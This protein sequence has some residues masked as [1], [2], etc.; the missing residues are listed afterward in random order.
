MPRGRPSGRSS[1]CS[2]SSNSSISSPTR[3]AILAAGGL[4]TEPAPPI[5]VDAEAGDIYLQLGAFSGRDN[6]E[7]FRI[8]VYQRLAWINDAIQI[9]SR[10]G[11]FRLHLGPYRNRYEANAIAEKIRAEL[12]F[13]PL[14]VNK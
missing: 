7:N 1:V 11:M 5:P 2:V 14:I 6:A 4:Q 13:K 3:P 10:D 9:S 8:R 12:D